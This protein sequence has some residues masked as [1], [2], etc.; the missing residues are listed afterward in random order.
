MGVA[1]G[2]ISF[3]M[4]FLLVICL[5][6]SAEAQKKTAQDSR[7]DALNTLQFSTVCTSCAA[8]PRAWCPPGSRRATQITGVKGCSYLV[9]LGEE[10]LT[11]S[12]CSHTC[13]KD[14]TEHKCCP[15]FWGPDC[16]PCPSKSGKPCNWKGTCMD[17]VTGN[18]TCIC[19]AGFSG[20]ACQECKDENVYGPDCQL[21]CDCVH[22]ICISGIGGNGSCICETGYTGVRCDQESQLCHGMDCG[23]NSVCN[24][25]AGGTAVC[26]CMP[27]F[28]KTGQQCLPQDPCAQN[29]CDH[30]ADCVNHGQ[31]KYDCRCKEAYQGDGKVCVPVNPCLIDN[32]GCPTNSTN[33]VYKSVGKT[34]CVCKS[35]M[36]GAN[37]SAGCTLKDVCKKDSCDKSA[38]C[39][40]G[41][42][43]TASCVCK[44]GQISD[45]TFC[46]GN[47]IE[48]ILELNTESRH[49]GKLT[50]A[51]NMFEKGCELALSKR[52]FTV[53][54]PASTFTVTGMSEKYLCK[55]H[56]IIGLHMFSDL[57][58]KVFWTLGGE[59]VHFMADK[60]FSFQRD[61]SKTY[62]ILQSDLA[63]ANG[64][65]HII[66]QP[67]TNIS[68]EHAENEQDSKKTIEEII[69]NQHKFSRYQTLLENCEMSPILEGPGPF[70]V[71]VPTN[72]AVDQHRDGTIIYLLT[73]VSMI[74]ALIPHLHTYRR[75]A[76]TVDRLAAMP[77][78]L[79]KANQIIT[80]NVTSDGRIVLGDKAVV[81]NQQDIVA[82]NGII[83]VI[84][85]ILIP[86]SIVPILPHRCD[87]TE[88][89]IVM[90][91]CVDCSK[92]DTTICPLGSTELDKFH[93]GCDY[94]SSVM[95]II[96]NRRGCAKYCN[97]TVV[98]PD[99]C[100]GFYGPDCKA[101]LG[102]F[103]NPCYQHGTCNDGI[104]G[105]G[106]CSCLPDFQGIACHICSNANK[107]GEMCDEDCKCLHGVCD[108]RP[109]SKGV[110]R[111]NSCAEG[112]TGEL[113]D[114]VTKPCGP[115]GLSQYCHINAVCD[116]SDDTR[117]ICRNGYEGDGFSCREMNP[118]Q[119]A[120]RGGCSANARCI[121]TSPGNATCICNEG[122][123]GDGQACVEIDNC[124]LNNRGGCHYNADCITQGPGQSECVC[125]KNYMGDGYNCDIINPCLQSN[126]G[127]HSL[128]KCKPLGDGER[129]CLCPEGYG[130]DGAICYG[131]ILT[132][133]LIFKSLFQSFFCSIQS[134]S[135]SNPE[136]NVTV[137][138]P[139]ENAIKGLKEEVRE[140]WMKPYMLPFLVRVHFLEG[141]FT[142]DDLK[143]RGDVELST[144]NPRTKWEV[145]DTSGTVMIQNASILI[146]DIPAVNGFIN[147]IDQVLIPSL[148]DIPPPPP[149]LMQVLNQTT[150]FSLFKK[151]LLH[152]NLTEKIDSS[153]K[154]T[155]LIPFNKAIED[156]L[157]ATGS[158]ELDED[159]V[160]YHIIVEERLLPGNLRN[161]IH[162][163]T[164]LGSSY[165]IMF[166]NNNEN[167][168]YA[169]EVP[170]N[171]VFYSTRNGMLMGIS[172]LLHIHKNRCDK[173][174]TILTK[175]FCGHCDGNHRCPKRA[176]P[177]THVADMAALKS[178]CKYR[179]KN[180]RLNGC[181]YQCLT[182]TEDHNC[183]PGYFGLNCF[184][185]PGMPGNWCSNNGICQD[186]VLGSGDCLCKEGFHGTACEDCE[187]G[188]H[189]TSCESECTC[190]H[191][192][193]L[194]GIGGDGK[195]VCYKGWKGANCTVEIVADPCNDTCDPNANCLT[196]LPGSLPTC[197][198]S[199]GYA[200]NGSFCSE[201][202]PC[203]SGNGG[204]SEHA[205]C[206]KISPGE[207]SCTC[208]EGYFGDGVVCIEKDGCLIDHGGCHRL[209]ECIKTGP[210]LV[211]C[212]CLPGYSGDGKMC[213]PINPCKTNN[214]G[215][216][217]FAWCRYT[218]PGSR[219]CS[220]R[221]SYV[222]DGLTCRGR[223]HRELD[224][225]PAASWFNK[226]AQTHMLKELNGDGPFTVF[227]PHQDY[228]SND[229][230]EEWK[231]KSLT[232]HMVRYHVVGCQTLL[233]SDIQSLSTL[234]TLSG[235]SLQISVEE[236][237]VYL[238]KEVKIVSS[239]FVTSNGV[240][241]FI[242]KV[243][244]PSDLQN[245]SDL[246]QPKKNVTET[247]ESHGYT[248][249]SK[250]LQDA[251]L[252]SMV[253][254]SLH[255]P[256][257]MLWPTDKV[258]NSLPDERKK[259]LYSEDHRDKLAA[260]IKAHIIRDNK[261]MAADLPNQKSLR[262]LYGSLISFACSRN[263]T[264]DIFVDDGNA[265]IVDRQIEFDVGIAY[266]IDQLL[267]PPNMGARCDDFV[268]TTVSG[269]CG[270]CSFTPS[271]PTGST[272]VRVSMCSHPYYYTSGL[273]HSPFGYR[274]RYHHLMNPFHHQL[275]VG[276]MKECNS[277]QWVAKCCKH[278]YGRDCQVCP[279]G[280]EAPCSNH[281]ACND[282]M[283]EQGKCNCS[284]GFTGTT[285][286]QCAP[287]RYGPDCRE[288][289]CTVHG[290]CA[291]GIDGDGS[292]FCKEGWTGE[293]CELQ[294]GVKPVCTPECDAN[295]VCQPNNICECDS[296]YEGDGRNCTVVDL[297]MDSNG[298]CH[299]HATCTQNDVSRTCTCLPAYTG[300]GYSCTAINRCVSDNGGCSEFATC[301]FT[302]P[303]ERRCE[304][305]EGFVGNGVQCLEKA[306]PP[307]DRCL[308][309][310][311]GCHPEAI[312]TDLHFEEKTAGV[313][314]VQSPKGKYKLTY[315]DAQAAC[316]AE[317]ATM[318][319]I[320]QLS[321]A[322]QFGYHSCAA[323]WLDSENVGYPTTNPS[324]NCGNNH[325]GVVLY[326][327]PGSLYDAY[328]YRI[329]DV[330]CVCRD[331]YV[332]DGDFCNGNLLDVVASNANFSVFY[333]TLLEYANYSSRGVELVDFLSNETT[334]ETLFVPADA[335]FGENETLSLRDLEYHISVND[336]FIF[337]DEM[338]HGTVIPS[339]LGYNLSVTVSSFKRWKLTN[340][341]K[342]VNDHLIVEWDIPA[343][344]GIL[345]VIERPLKAP[346]P[347]VL[348]AVA[349]ASPHSSAAVVSTVLA[350]CL[351]AVAAGGVLYF[352][353]K[354]KNEGFHFRYFK[355]DEDE[356]DGMP[357]PAEGRSS[358]VSVPNPLFSGYNAFTEPFDETTD[359]DYSDTQNILG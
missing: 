114:R 275:S 354:P 244:V 270:S 209:A 145:K 74:S 8:V 230:I 262:T 236:D 119:K 300:D 160:R 213:L 266:G 273:F 353:F 126:G 146:S 109:G 252:L 22:G 12:G 170:L 99:C 250:L 248:I 3:K 73:D 149:G 223:L 208:T 268:T 335:G 147:V 66:N 183:C 328:C 81:L 165:Q 46:Y 217:D 352:C 200:G 103:Q 106:T 35:G 1:G 69:A 279:G 187:P 115:S 155:I 7:C 212:N 142:I 52:L 122:W 93:K 267:E 120:D 61:Q 317:G 348:S 344:N 195:C 129:E 174:V 314:H 205:N 296:L 315:S 175:G 287:N 177:L 182:V 307:L 243:L 337:Y 225:E 297:C 235:S 131:N 88:Y 29:V 327:K 189:G 203:D 90:G 290:K 104:Q 181:S 78:I 9:D 58:D 237:T 135:L 84:D 39:V 127:C 331:G 37:P 238:N 325:V 162:K 154:Y 101:C 241:H 91:Q 357:S 259:W 274:R 255:H 326:N 201:I 286:G 54:V 310:N 227:V 65:I 229:T 176:I 282:G 33:C 257:T 152:Y 232:G 98:R 56:M 62:R 345:H 89:N 15:G 117:C 100:K 303:N 4:F 113:C 240:I 188:R 60:S 321:A 116:Y 350:V 283:A 198:C 347:P 144:L 50:S 191:G 68:P 185:C 118:C 336:S 141:A 264:G 148:A 324:L 41:L 164:M 140:F 139:S 322:Q 75:A 150:S 133:D 194:D 82:S 228:I 226:K 86:P 196:G 234:V 305:N 134:S 24:E 180:K 308:E 359:I 124:L 221:F 130:G 254:N 271:C 323:G 28:Q 168:T 173:N 16:M 260:Y 49:K 239:D 301:I 112:Y 67:V 121:Y 72:E 302:G 295:A 276:C 332:G 204:C 27:G 151:A 2:L 125:K 278:H 265:K 38:K 6:L 80:V 105:N 111:I 19:E 342:L 316:Q 166:H 71:F 23:E 32:G 309:E 143:Q 51:I 163:S 63:A 53:F 197:S 186:G 329:K 97:K 233:L 339:R 45:G 358:L 313:F 199:A 341:S 277:T 171:G 210:N 291:E 261:I 123:A 172:Q 318:A 215:C 44:K 311:G 218:E 346:P 245:K 26:G 231:N 340:G 299:E 70:T 138:V 333:S 132:V 355:A 284:L 156:H 77:Q 220:C 219:N 55:L 25:G 36:E 298:G 96:T 246:H 30:N 293:N 263:I 18:G 57:Q 202:N 137:L 108:N 312:C 110:C 349:P 178:N 31:R 190:I 157:N 20:F 216:S 351:L 247:A 167:Q 281:G 47:I 319:T 64:I 128:A 334:Y 249:F 59:P 153:E 11:L 193:C 184:K 169:N 206:T 242:D 40:T 258:F 285:C 17:G 294:L 280:L 256:F 34:L 159:S 85:G 21:E 43:G 136:G 87:V 330:S 211:G 13:E 343:S 79:T 224:R 179:K 76:V 304:C 107:H 222:G 95:N 102:G 5:M 251:G 269:R 48:R 158:E 320:A 207:R 253:Q 42:D 161:G 292:C 356:D 272:M 306:F 288:C 94:I 289:S 92:L 192:K 338:S 10:T 83:H 214:G 14:V